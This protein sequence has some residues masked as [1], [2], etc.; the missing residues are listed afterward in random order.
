MADHYERVGAD[1]IVRDFS[2]AGVST[3]AKN[4]RL[5]ERNVLG[6]RRTLAT[7][8]GIGAGYLGF[9]GLVQGY[10]TVIKA[11]ADAAASE[12]YFQ[13][14]M[15][16]TAEQARSFSDEVAA[17]YGVNGRAMRGQIATLKEMATNMGAAMEPRMFSVSHLAR[18]TSV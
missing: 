10:K 16:R 13:S 18:T 8:F 6:M 5:V 7:A 17:A 2:S 4:M 15:G 3:F 11:A 9:Q 12:R 1:L 14:A